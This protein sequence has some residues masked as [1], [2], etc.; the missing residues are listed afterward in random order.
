MPELLRENHIFFYEDAQEVEQP[1]PQVAALRAALLDFDCTIADQFALRHDDDINT[2][3]WE[4]AFRLRRAKK[5]ECDSVRAKLT[6]YRRT[7]Q[8]A[9][10]LHD[11][12]DQDTEWKKYYYEHF[13]EPLM[14]EAAINEADSRRSVACPRMKVT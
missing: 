4:H 2:L 8:K 5:A 7:K 9:W 3:D 10:L 11:G 12:G 6:K 1:P 14:E 13:F